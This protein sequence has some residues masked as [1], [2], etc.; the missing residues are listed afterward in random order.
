MIRTVVLA[1]GLMLGSVVLAGPALADDQSFL[2][3]LQ[4]HG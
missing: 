2:N 3:Y 4:S 1:A